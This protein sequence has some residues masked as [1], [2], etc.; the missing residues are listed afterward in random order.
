M[1]PVKVRVPKDISEILDLLGSMLASAPKFIDKTGWLPFL[2]LDYVF[3]QLNQG[4][5]NNRQMLGEE[6]YHNLMR[7]S[8][9]MRALFEADPEDKTGDTLKGRKIMRQMEDIVSKK[10]HAA[11]LANFPY[12]IVET[13]GEN[14]LAL[15]EELKKAGRGAPV[16]LGQEEL[17]NLLFPF[18]PEVSAQRQPVEE[19]L[20][21]AKVVN[22]PDDLFKL[23]QDAEAEAKAYLRKGSISKTRNMNRRWAIGPLRTDMGLACPL[24][25]KF[26]TASPRLRYALR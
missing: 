15:W 9:Q 25:T 13:S 8:D 16:V 6:H 3:Q 11:T 14:A 10:V 23:R 18:D 22:F 21:A 24:R 19:I 7:M 17:H 26:E 1:K 5:S 12:E 4:L 20:A 2:N